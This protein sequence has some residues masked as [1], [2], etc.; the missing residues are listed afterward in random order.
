MEEKHGKLYWACHH[1]SVG[2]RNAWRAWRWQ[3]VLVT[4]AIVLFLI[5]ARAWVQPAVLAVRIYSFELLVALVSLAALVHYRS[6]LG[7]RSWAAVAG[8]V[9]AIVVGHFGLHLEPHNY[10]TLY[11]T[12]KTLE[13]EELQKLPET[14][15]ERIHPLNSIRIQAQGAMNEVQQMSDPFSVMVGNDYRWT[16]SVQPSFLRCLFGVVS[17]VLSVS[18]TS[19]SPNFSQENRHEVCFPVGEKLWL[20]KNTHIATIRSFG[21]WRF[22]SFQPA[23]VKFVKDD[24]GEWVQLVSL[25]RWRGVIFPSPEFGGVQVIRQSSGGFLHW[26]QLMFAGEGEWI[27]PEKVKDYP[28]L[29]GQNLV[30]YEVGRY[31][32]QSFRFQ[33]GFLAPLPGI[34]SGEV[35]IPDLPGDANDQPFVTYFRFAGSDEDSKLYQYFALEPYEEVRKGLNTSI[36]FPVDD[37]GPVKIYCHA[38]RKEALVGVSTIAAMVMESRKYYDWNNSQP[39][40]HRPYIRFLEGKMRFM[41]MTTVVTQEKTKAAKDAIAGSM[42]EVAITDAKYRRVVWMKPGESSET[43][44][45]E[46][47]KEL[48]PVWKAD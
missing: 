22:L 41:W 35:R 44:P 11:L 47:V 25:I 3:F 18:A 19:P 10:V 45:E 21:F 26:F 2:V 1:A 23:D 40:E 38:K 36:F 31:V 48:G 7:W 8:V 34:H 12:Y 27:P 28:F 13:V 42:P 29:R 17:E 32:A 46:V 24:N 14:G 15:Y 43:W 9:L 5:I 16:M 33:N 4:I 30:P 37:I 6:R 39:A 20:G